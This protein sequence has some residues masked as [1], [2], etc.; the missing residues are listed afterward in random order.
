MKEMN[1]GKFFNILLMSGLTCFGTL[2][3]SDVPDIPT[4]P[5]ETPAKKTAK[6]RFNQKLEPPSEKE[7]PANAPAQFF[8]GLHCI[9]NPKLNRVEEGYKFLELAAKQNYRDA[10]I[11]LAQRYLN[12]CEEH[13]SYLLWSKLCYMAAYRLKAD[14]ETEF[15]IGTVEGLMGNMQEF[16]KW[17]KLAAE[18][19]LKD[20]SQMLNDEE[21]KKHIESIAE[22]KKKEKPQSALK[23]AVASHMNTMRKLTGTTGPEVLDQLMGRPEVSRIS[24][25]VSTPIQKKFILKDWTYDPEA[26]EEY[27]ASRLMAD[28]DG[29]TRWMTEDF[30]TQPIWDNLLYPNPTVRAINYSYEEALEKFLKKSPYRLCTVEE[31]RKLIKPFRFEGDRDEY[32]EDDRI[33]DLGNNL[34]FRIHV[35]EGAWRLRDYQFF[36]VKNGESI[37]AVNFPGPPSALDAALAAGVAQGDHEC[38]NNLAVKFADGEMDQVCRRDDEAEEILKVIVDQNHLL[39]TYNLGVFY[40]NRSD[41]ANARKYFEM[42]EKLAGKSVISYSIHLPEIFDRNG[43]LLVKN[44]FYRKRHNPGRV[45]TKGGKF[46]ASLIGHVSTWEDNFDGPQPVGREVFSKRDGVEYMIIDKNI[47]HPVYLTIDSTMQSRLE[48]L[49][50]DIDAKSTPLYAY[51]VIVSSKGELV[52]AAQNIVFDLEKRDF[53]NDDEWNFNFMPSGYL[54]PVADQ[55]MKLLNSSS[56]ADPLSKEKLK[57]HIKQG[58]FQGEA[59]G[60]VLGLNKMK[61]NNNVKQVSGQTSTMLNYLCAYIATA[62]KKDISALTVYTDKVNSII[63]PKSDIKW[64]SFYRPADGIVVNALGV[65]KSGDPKENLY[66]CIRAVGAE[67]NFAKPPTEE[68][69][70]AAKVKM[71][72]AEKIIREFTIR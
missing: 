36:C 45:Y 57:L 55:W 50:T 5:E 8:Y 61:G 1:V 71:D 24:K 37:E 63:V 13:E 6:P 69:K 47:C 38:L 72:M 66:I 40:Q 67:R 27:V 30:F 48:K 44:S 35:S 15:Q 29:G 52:A 17:M 3:A 20:A 56:Y 7:S 16:T 32:Y 54:F 46:A 51:G 60:V 14:A 2:Q 49:I 34:Y 59:Q 68:M 18:K 21:V 53:R 4:A 64:I 9:E 58:I 19:G 10:W 65:I 70:K 23:Q 26:V 11:V 12:R 62:E 43:E 33:W 42:A 25:M 41:E 31:T 28:R 22:Q 39:G